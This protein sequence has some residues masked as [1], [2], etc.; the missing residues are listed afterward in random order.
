MEEY[1][2]QEVLRSESFR[3]GIDAKDA[4]RLVSLAKRIFAS[5][6]YV[7]WR[8]KANP[9]KRPPAVSISPA[10]S[11]SFG[12]A[13]NSSMKPLAKKKKTTKTTPGSFTASSQSP[14]KKARLEPHLEPAKR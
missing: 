3:P 4:L 11:G 5:G 6:S 1:A 7:P 2:F 12:A 14:A 10:A 8:A 9:H 13:S